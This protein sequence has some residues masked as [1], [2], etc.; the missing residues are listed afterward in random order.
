MVEEP[1]GEAPDGAAPLTLS[2]P[3]RKLLESLRER[4]DPP[5]E[6]AELSEHTGVPIETVRGSLQ[7]LRSKHLA[8]VD[9]EHEERPRLT[10]RGETAFRDG[11]PE[12]RFL[13]LLAE[14]AGPL[15]PEAAAAG[16]DEEERSAAIGLLRRR[17][18]LEP[19][20]PFRLRA[21]APAS[22]GPFPEEKVLQSIGGGDPEVDDTVLQALKKRGL[23]AVDR[24]SIKRWGSSEEGRRL[25]LAPDG[26]E[27]LGSLTPTILSSGVWEK[28]PFRPYDVRAEVPFLRGAKPHP[29]LAW[30]EEFEEILLGLG[31][32]QGEGP[33]LETEFWNGDVLFMPQD[34][35]ARTVHD[36]LHV[37]GVVGHPPP[38][39]LLERVAA[40]HEGR[41][42][43]GERSSI[44]P[45]WRTP[46]DRAFAAHPVLRSQTTAVSA[47]FL[48]THPRPPFRMFCIDRNFRRDPVD[49]THHVE[50]GQCEGILGEEGVNL[51]HLVGMF[52]ALTEAI[53][54]KEL[55]FRPSYFPFT[56]PSIEG[57]IRHPRLGWIEVFPGGL[58]R[59][60]VLAPLGID[61]PVA[62]WGIGVTRLAMVALGVNDIR[63]LFLDDLDRLTGGS[64]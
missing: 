10:P 21:D 53:G 54:V 38:A 2:A 36:V 5:W 49:S 61:V 64:A 50:F 14:T 29:Y 17:G 34:H 16:F 32:E 62:A 22:T 13:R 31:F 41:P 46:Y 40:V 56:E 58:F 30:V 12:R 4:A 37:E 35:P 39:E 60:E 57:Y 11:L 27:T 7:R 6:E 8:V 9:E 63:D 42:M 23:V 47:R 25:P 48:S 43:P 26:G 33:L 44:T 1:T 28:T 59:P 18:F 19:G 24:R 20:V 3:E 55:K 52:R 51:R 45:G 15:S